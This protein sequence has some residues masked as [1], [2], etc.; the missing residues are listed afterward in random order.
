MAAIRYPEILQAWALDRHE[1]VL[2]RQSWRLLAAGDCWFCGGALNPHR[3]SGLIGQLGF[4]RS[5]AV[6]IGSQLGDSMSHFTQL[7][8]EPWFQDLLCGGRAR[9]WSGILLS[10]G[11]GDLIDA[12]HVTPSGPAAGDASLRLLLKPEEWGP[13]SQGVGRFLSAGGWRRFEE[14]LTA[15]LEHIVAIR[16]GEGSRS[17][18]APIFLH[19]YAYPTPRDA[20][21][22]AQGPW[23]YPAMRQYQLPVTEWFAIS[24]ELLTRMAALLARIAADGKRFPN[25]HVFDSAREVPLEP[26]HLGDTGNSGDWANE[27]HLNRKGSAKI[28]AAWGAR[29]EKVLKSQRAVAA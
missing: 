17:R 5:A 1:T 28:G 25:L 6:V 16:D 21:A 14:Y 22:G 18:G 12:V 26:A 2:S 8:V 15:N 24:R 10:A 23:L 19:T 29:I 4:T 9:A 13:A 3:H 11:G 20:P 7:G 27:I